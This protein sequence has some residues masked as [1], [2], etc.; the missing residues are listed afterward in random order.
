MRNQFKSYGY[1]TIYLLIWRRRRRRKKKTTE[2][3][4]NVEEII[5][6]STLAQSIDPENNNNKIKEKLAKKQN[7]TQKW[8]QITLHWN[9]SPRKRERSWLNTQR[10]QEYNYTDPIRIRQ[11]L[12]QNYFVHI[13][14]YCFRKLIS[15]VHV[16]F[17]PSQTHTVTRSLP[18][19]I[20]ISLLILHAFM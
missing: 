1:T 12:S 15:P 6:T 20:Y 7:K 8:N 13:A 4:G 9:A 11:I 14:I 10:R 16:H 5:T 3:D 2:D 17:V 18:L 19:T